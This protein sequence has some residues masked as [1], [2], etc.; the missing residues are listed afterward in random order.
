MSIDAHLRQITAQ[1]IKQFHANPER[2][3]D[4]IL[5]KAKPPVV[6]GKLKIE[7]WK[8]RNALALLPLFGIASLDELNA[9]D[10]LA[11]E[12]AHRELGDIT[13]EL[14]AHAVKSLAMRKPQTT[15]RGLSLDKT[16][17]GIHFLLT[18]RNEGGKSPL[19]WAVR[20][21]KAIPDRFVLI[22]RETSWCHLY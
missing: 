22:Q 12:K 11:F 15:P 6:D 2:A 18:G 7:D 21:A 13:R 8:R 14:A 5:G 10:R 9:T 1:Q 4:L 20:G 19:S 16:W 3:Y 17:Q